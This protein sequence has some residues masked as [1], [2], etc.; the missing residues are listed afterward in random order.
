MHPNGEF[1]FSTKAL[2]D[3]GSGNQTY[4]AILDRVQFENR[5]LEYCNTNDIPIAISNVIYSDNDI[6][7]EM[8]NQMQL[9]EN[10]LPYFYKRKIFE[11]QQ[12]RRILIRENIDSLEK[13]GIGKAFRDGLIIRIGSL[14][15]IGY[16]GMYNIFH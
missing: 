1:Y 4:C 2:K 15:D 7:Y 14:S 11:E 6:G 3:F 9:G 12:E 8:I 5:I 10:P 13:R 16:I